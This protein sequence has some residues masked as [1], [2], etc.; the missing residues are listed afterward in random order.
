MKRQSQYLVRFSTPA[1]LGNAW[2]KDAFCK[3]GVRMNTQLVM[4]RIAGK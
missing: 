4:G 1:F 2:L 3:S